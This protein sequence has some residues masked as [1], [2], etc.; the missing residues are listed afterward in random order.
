MSEELCPD[1]VVCGELGFQ[2]FMLRNIIE[3]SV[4]AFDEIRND[5]NDIRSQYIALGY[6]LD[7]FKT[8]GYYKTFGFDSFEDFVEANFH[9]EKSALSRCLN[10]FYEFSARKGS[11]HQPVIDEAF[12]EYNYSQLT[13]LVSM[14]PADR[15]LVSSDMSVSKIRDLKKSLKKNVNQ[16]LDGVLPD[17]P[18]AACAAVPVSPPGASSHSEFNPEKDDYDEPDPDEEAECF[19][20]ETAA[21]PSGDKFYNAFKFSGLKGI[22]KINYLVKSKPINSAVGFAFYSCTGSELNPAT[23]I[24]FIA[25]GK[26]FDYLGFDQLRNCMVFRQVSDKA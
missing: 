5:F 15:K 25:L 22:A 4:R 23:V 12:E 19:I 2:K 6:K 9:I 24:E 13:E 14:A 16:V 10:V 18:P 21:A 1:Y 8:N 20:P 17:V 11:A 3:K 7:E 26:N